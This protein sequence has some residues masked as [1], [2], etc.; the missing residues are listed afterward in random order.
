MRK[1][2]SF[3]LLLGIGIFL[4]PFLISVA[5]S[6]SVEGTFDYNYEIVYQEETHGRTIL[7]AL[8]HEKWTGSFEG[9][10][11][12][13]FIVI[14]DEAGVPTVDLFSTFTGIVDGKSGSLVIHLIGEKSSPDGD[15]AGDWDIVRGI[16][17][18]ENL[19]G[20]GTW[21][22]PGYEGPRP[23]E[24]NWDPVG[25]GN[26]RPDIWY[27]GTVSTEGVPEN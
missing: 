7:Y 20:Q 6:Q 2:I 4:C 23:P 8:E 12:A 27:K 25:E 1:K 9:N 13:V 21:G 14:V 26:T 11:H 16:G 3:K 24:E 15:W 19:R 5:H 17:K 10:A 18:L 22:G